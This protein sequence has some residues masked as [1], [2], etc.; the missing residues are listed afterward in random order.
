MQVSENSTTMNIV[1]ILFRRVDLLHQ[2]RKWQTLQV[3]AEFC[4][5]NTDM[6]KENS[7]TSNLLNL[8]KFV[9]TI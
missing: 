6:N 8:E 9:E 4:R 5:Y 1:I 2:V 3:L 7:E